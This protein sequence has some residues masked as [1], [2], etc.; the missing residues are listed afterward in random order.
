VISTDSG[1]ASQKLIRASSAS[2]P[3]VVRIAIEYAP[4]AM[5]PAWP[6]LMIPV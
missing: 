6:K 3:P 2:G 1:S 4:T 5:N